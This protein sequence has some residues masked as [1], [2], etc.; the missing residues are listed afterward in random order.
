MHNTDFG[1]G[2][3]IWPCFAHFGSLQRKPASYT[4]RAWL[5]ELTPKISGQNLSKWRRYRQNKTARV[6][7]QLMNKIMYSDKLPAS[8]QTYWRHNIS[9][10]ALSL[11][12]PSSPSLPQ[13]ADYWTARIPRD[14]TRPIA[15][16]PLSLLVDSCHVTTSAIRDWTSSSTVSGYFNAVPSI[17]RV[18]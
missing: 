18:R 16:L 10:T 9:A 6:R 7:I 3:H 5:D 17:L 2:G 15:A 4:S 13:L 14:R 8:C 11:P 12:L 1:L